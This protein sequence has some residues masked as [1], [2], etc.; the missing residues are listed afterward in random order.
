MFKTSNQI[1][2]EKSINQKVGNKNYPKIKI[3]KNNNKKQKKI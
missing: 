1:Q 2:N 3:M